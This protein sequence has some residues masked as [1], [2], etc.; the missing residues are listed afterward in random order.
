RGSLH[1]LDA[2]EPAQERK[3][4]VS[5]DGERGAN[6]VQPFGTEIA[7]AAHGALFDEQLLSLGMHAHLERRVL[8][9]LRGAEFEKARLRNHQDVGEARLQPAEIEW[10]KGAVR[11]LQRGAGD[12]GVRYLV[13]F[14]GEADLVEDFERGRMNGIAAK[15]AVK[16]LMH[17]EQGDGNAA[18]R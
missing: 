12:L 5:S 1:R 6:F 4:P 16:I 10:C 15:F 2:S 9:C 18:T 14:V 3:A 13:K 17:F 7:D 11:E 8:L